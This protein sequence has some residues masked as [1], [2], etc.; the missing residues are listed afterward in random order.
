[1]NFVKSAAISRNNSIIVWRIFFAYIIASFHFLNE[2]GIG[3][4]LYLATDFFFI[5]SGFLL[6]YEISIDKY[7]SAAAL[8]VH[9]VKKYYPHYLFSLVIS[10]IVFILLGK[11]PRIEYKSL[12][13]ELFMLQMAGTNPDSLLNVPT[14][15]ISVLLIASYII[16]YLYKNHRKLYVEFIVPVFLLVVGA[17]FYRNCGCLSHS[18]LGSDITTGVY[19]NRPLLLGFGMMSIGILLYEMYIKCQCIENRTNIL[20]GGGGETRKNI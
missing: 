10:I 2:Y 14:W 9:K 16:F 8:I 4:S 3:T 17:W 19:W 11:G 18:T 6:G 13:L 12:F 15:Y 1:M 5:V 7:N 20:G